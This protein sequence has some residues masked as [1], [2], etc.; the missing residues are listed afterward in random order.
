MSSLAGYLNLLSVNALYAVLKV[1][2][3]PPPDATVSRAYAVSQV[4][5]GRSGYYR[6]DID[7]DGAVSLSMST[8]LPLL[9]ARRVQ[10][11]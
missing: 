5:L 10:E 8:Y 7:S 4:V 9:Y 6:L 2:Y 3:I 1:C 11:M